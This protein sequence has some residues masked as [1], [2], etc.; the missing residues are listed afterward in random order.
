[1]YRRPIRN[2]FIGMMLCLFVAP[3]FAAIQTKPVS[4]TDKEITMKGYLAW[5]DSSNKA[6]PGILVVHEWWGHDDYARKRARMLAEEGYLAMSI[7]MYGDGKVATHPDQAGAFSSATMGN[8]EK[9]EKRFQAAMQ[10]LNEHPLMLKNKM[11]AIGYCFGGGVVLHM[12]RIGTD[13]KGVASFHG[14]LAGKVEAEKNQVSAQVLVLHGADD[15]FVPQK[16]VEAFETEMKRANAT[17]EIIQYPGAKHGFT[18]PEA[19]EIAQ[20]F[21][22]PLAYDRE[23]D[24]KSWKALK[25]FLAKVFE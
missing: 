22:L 20:H 24:K 11:A 21:S 8:L 14:S 19:D 13:L 7:D 12:A 2:T 6:R 25:E 9:A 10:V 4:Y 17:Y 18:N 15:S 16:D 1:M 5:D 23:A 3:V